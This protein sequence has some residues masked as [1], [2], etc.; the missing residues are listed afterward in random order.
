MQY[1]LVL[2]FGGTAFPLDYTTNFA[3]DE[4]G[5]VRTTQSSAA[6][7]TDTVYSSLYIVHIF[8]NVTRLTC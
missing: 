3:S 8:R 7:P 6:T 1:P 5:D 2:I 4:K